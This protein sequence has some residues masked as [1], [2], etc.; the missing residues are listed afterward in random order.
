MIFSTQLAADLADCDTKSQWVDVLKTALG[1]GYRLVARQ[2]GVAKITVTYS[3]EIQSNSVQAWLGNNYANLTLESGDKDALVWRVESSNGSNW[4]QLSVPPVLSNDPDPNQG[5]TFKAPVYM[6]APSNLPNVASSD[7]PLG[8]PMQRNAEAW[9][10]YPSTLPEWSSTYTARNVKLPDHRNGL[11]KHYVGGVLVGEYTGPTALRQ[12][13]GIKYSWDPDPPWMNKGGQAQLFEVYPA[14]YDGLVDDT[15]SIN[16]LFIGPK[17]GQPKLLPAEYDA[18]AYPDYDPDYDPELPQNITIRGMEVDGYIPFIPGYGGWGTSYQGGMVTVSGSKNITIE[19]MIFSGRMADGSIPPVM[20][21]DAAII[22]VQH[23]AENFVLRNCIVRDSDFTTKQGLLCDYDCIGSLTIEGCEFYNHGGPQGPAHAIYVGRSW[24]D[25]NFTF[26]FKNNFVHDVRVGFTVKSRAFN[27]IIEGNYLRCD[28]PKP[29]PGDI[30]STYAVN[31]LGAY[32]VGGTL[33][34][35]GVTCMID[36]PWGGN[37]QIRNNLCVRNYSH[38]PGSGQFLRYYS[39]DWGQSLLIIKGYYDTF[40]EP[41]DPEDPNHGDPLTG[42]FVLQQ[43]YVV[44]YTLGGDP[45]RPQSYVLRNNTFVTLSDIAYTSLD[46]RYPMYPYLFANSFYDDPEVTNNK[47]LL[48]KTRPVGYNPGVGKDRYFPDN[49]TFDAGNNVWVG[50][51][52]VYPTL[53]QYP[54]PTYSTGG[55][56]TDVLQLP[57]A[58]TDELVDHGGINSTFQLITPVASVG[59]SGAGYTMY[60]HKCLGGMRTDTYKGAR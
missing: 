13:F 49:F 59:A 48:M 24:A 33:Y 18:D 51:P 21:W 15:P 47:I 41:T 14:I 46:I 28:G 3:G 22:R 45:T 40:G 30:D 23:H 42:D 58:E 55:V 11:V 12:I 25:P 4:A 39:E 16:F 29:V 1:A 57:P 7:D 60:E 56:D 19:N 20:G 5:L 32:N 17:T 52:I 10:G 44:G 6:R 35:R 26:V 9:V 54:A 37:A 2:S 38:E 27:N 34:F 50:L 31:V 43:P 8:A 36:L 53:D